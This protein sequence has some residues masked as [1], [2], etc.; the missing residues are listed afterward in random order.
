M[1]VRNTRLRHY[2]I[3]EELA[4]Q[5]RVQATLSENE[6]LLRF[7]AEQS[8]EGI[9]DYLVES[10]VCRKSYERLALEKDVPISRNDFYAYRR[11]TMYI[12]WLLLTGRELER[13]A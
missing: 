2:G 6:K 10:F 13:G 3:D 12:F 9:A 5:L 1:L 11:L 8:N 7:A 4:K